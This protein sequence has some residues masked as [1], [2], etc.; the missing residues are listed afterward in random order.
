MRLTLV[1]VSWGAAEETGEYRPAIAYS[2]IGLPEGQRAVI[3]ERP[4]GWTVVTEELIAGSWGVCYPS[5]HDALDALK[6]Y[7]ERSVAGRA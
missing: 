1:P 7:V 2:V 5:A 3:A 4:G 6:A